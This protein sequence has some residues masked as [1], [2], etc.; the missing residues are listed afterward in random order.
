MSPLKDWLKFICGFRKRR[1]VCSN[2]WE[3]SFVTTLLILMPLTQKCFGGSTFVNFSFS[4]IG[5][6][7]NKQYKPRY[8]LARFV[9]WNQSSEY[10]TKPVFF[11]IVT[12]EYPWFK[13]PPA[14]L[15]KAVISLL[16]L[17]A[18]V[19]NHDGPGFWANLKCFKVDCTALFPRKDVALG[20]IWVF[21]PLTSGV[22]R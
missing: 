17:T 10:F 15:V 3:V 20:K 22:T 21:W 8:K 7:L 1:S 13:G 16:T 6:K 18:V 19:L 2:I 5:E 14:S 9:C 12:M 11:N 4:L